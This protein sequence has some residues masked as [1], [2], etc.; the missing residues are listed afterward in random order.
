M[1]KKDIFTKILAILGIVLVWF[2]ILVPIILMLIDLIKMR[3]FRIDYL[4]PA[5]LFPSALIGGVLLVWAARRARS[6]LK[7]I[8]WSLGVA[9]FFL[10][11]C[12]VLAEIT[13]LA[14]GASEPTGWRWAIVIG[15][16]GVFI[17]ALIVMG[18]GGI[19][20]VR[21]LYKT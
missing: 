3:L 15:S 18:V 4:M 11:G 5:E 19:L 17:L 6:R 12:Q 2:P 9:I 10:V 1:P 13:G 8:G 21:D 16:L 14:S 20:L 7:L